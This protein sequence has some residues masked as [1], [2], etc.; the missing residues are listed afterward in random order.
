M[1]VQVFTCLNCDQQWRRPTVRGAYPK[2][3]PP[4]RTLCVRENAR[5][6]GCG[7]KGVRHRERACSRWCGIYVRTGRWPQVSVPSSHPSRV[8]RCRVPEEHP[9]RRPLPRPRFH[10]GCCAECG[11]G[12]VVDSTFVTQVVRYCSTTCARRTGRRARRAREHGATGTFT[13][14][15]FMRLTLSLGNACAYCGGDNGGSQFEPDHVLP[16]SRGGHNGLANILPACRAC[17]GDKRDL[18]VEEWAEDRAARSLPPRR[19]DIGRFI[20]LTA[21]GSPPLRAAG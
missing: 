17:N 13:W 14:D 2:W 3:C 8:D 20:H 1:S 4:C 21:H 7:S 18:L 11:A 10:A 5:C 9:S 15:G 6:E 19:Y 16:I 12:F